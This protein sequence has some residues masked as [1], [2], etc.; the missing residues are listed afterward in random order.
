MTCRRGEAAPWWENRVE[1]MHLRIR[2]TDKALIQHAARAEGL[3]ASRFL[4]EAATQCAEE[5]IARQNRF[6]VPQERWTEVVRALDR[7]P[8]PHG[9]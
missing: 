8:D 4:V 5:C 7:G 3:S 6:V 2:P 9:H 1:Y